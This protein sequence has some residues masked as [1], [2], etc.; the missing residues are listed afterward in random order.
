MQTTITGVTRRSPL[1]ALRMSRYRYKGRMGKK[2]RYQRE[3]SMF[4][5]LHVTCLRFVSW[6]CVVLVITKGKEPCA[7]DRALLSRTMILLI[8]RNLWLFYLCCWFNMKVLNNNQHLQCELRTVYVQGQPDHVNY[9]LTQ[10]RHSIGNDS[11]EKSQ[12]RT[13]YRIKVKKQYR[14]R[15]PFLEAPGN[16]RAH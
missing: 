14:L 2:N 3:V 9:Q 16:Y 13:R 6:A 11:E 10:W 5:I 4:S 8:N 1:H 7:V 15:G 12:Y